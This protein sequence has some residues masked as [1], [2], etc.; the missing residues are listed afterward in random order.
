[1][2]HHAQVTNGADTILRQLFW[3]ELDLR[4]YTIQGW[5]P[6][7]AV[8]SRQRR[9][10]DVHISATCSHLLTSICTLLV[11]PPSH[12]RYH[13][14]TPPV[15][16]NNGQKVHGTFDVFRSLEILLNCRTTPKSRHGGLVWNCSRHPRLCRKTGRGIMGPFEPRLRGFFHPY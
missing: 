4:N 11:N 16:A 2:L 12:T 13:H 1:M 9:P 6:L 10:M 14:E 8:E 7:P 3:L 15:F 5:I